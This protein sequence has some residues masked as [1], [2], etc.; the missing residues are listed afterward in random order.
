MMIARQSV[1][2]FAR[3]SFVLFCDFLTFLPRMNVPTLLQGEPL[4]TQTN[5]KTYK[6]DLVIHFGGENMPAELPLVLK[7]VFRNM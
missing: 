7:R 2:S 4:N 1:I 6:S 5:V 3:K